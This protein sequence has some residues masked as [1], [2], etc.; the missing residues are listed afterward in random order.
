MSDLLVTVT[1]VDL[2]AAIDAVHVRHVYR[3]EGC[4]L[5]QALT[6]T[7]GL[8]PKKDVTVGV[9]T[10]RVGDVCM[11]LSPAAQALADLF[12]EEKFD[13]LRSQLPQTVTFRPLRVKA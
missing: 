11:A 1:A 6:R 12:D 13:A 5:A 7:T 9:T 10:A 4:L 2:D 3:S 8:E